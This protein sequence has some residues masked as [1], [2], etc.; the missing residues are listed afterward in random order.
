MKISTW[1]TVLGQVGAPK[2]FLLLL[3]NSVQQPSCDPGSTTACHPKFWG[4]GW[5]CFEMVVP[6]LKAIDEQILTLGIALYLYLQDPKRGA[7]KCHSAHQLHSRHRPEHGKCQGVGCL[8]GYW[9]YGQ[10]ALAIAAIAE[11]HLLWLKVNCNSHFVA[12]LAT[13]RIPKVG[14]H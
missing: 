5:I 2:L 4:K 12:V 6:G 9:F 11:R 8:I 14:I 13:L 1:A 7:C 3:C 10:I